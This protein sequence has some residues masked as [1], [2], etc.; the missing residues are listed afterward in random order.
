MIW[1]D[2]VPAS[3][4]QKLRPSGRFLWSATAGTVQRLH[5]PVEELL[6]DDG[7]DVEKAI[8]A[9]RPAHDEGEVG[10]PVKGYVRVVGLL[11][12]DQV[13]EADGGESDEAK[14]VIE[15]DLRVPPSLEESLLPEFPLVN[16][17]QHVG[18]EGDDPFQEQVEEEDGTRT[19]EEA[20]EDHDNA[21]GQ[22]FR[23]CHAKTSVLLLISCFYFS[24]FG[25]DN[26]GLTESVFWSLF[27]PALGLFWPRSVPDAR[28][29]F[30]LRRFCCFFERLVSSAFWFLL[31]SPPD[32]LSQNVFV[33]V[34]FYVFCSCVPAEDS[35]CTNELL[36]GTLLK[37]WCRLPELFLRVVFYLLT[38]VL[39]TN[40][41]FIL[42]F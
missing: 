34:C 17:P 20:V 33:D 21:T 22:S 19:P 29:V 12:S 35:F 6:N 23:S 36:S 13:T 39:H 41:L 3:S 5:E 31:T 18:Q 1:G 28:C 8:N 26:D 32:F 16:H 15:G 7:C 11:R 14:V 9:A 40:E 42:D 25:P 24:C 38:C 37:S 2:S 27:S 4:G 10:H 30:F